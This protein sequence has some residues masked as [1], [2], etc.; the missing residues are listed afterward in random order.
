MLLRR[1]PQRFD[2]LDRAEEVRTLEEDGGS[3]AV[4]RLGQGGGLGH[5]AL[6][7]DLDHL[8]AVA[9]CVGGER[10]AAVRVDAA[11][12]HELLALGRAHRQVAGGGE[13]G[14]SL[15]ETGAGD[16]QP[17]QLRH[18]RLELEHHLQPTLGD[19]RLVGR[20]RR[21]ELA[22]RG[23][24]VDDRRHVVVVHPRAD[25]ADLLFG[26][27]VAR[28]QR[29]QPLVDLGL[30]QPVRQR[31]RPAQAQGLGDLLEELG[32]GGDADRVEHLPAVIGGRGG[33]AGHLA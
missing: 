10:L 3:L 6:E 12:D 14:R 4:D 33:V 9:D 26:V 31:Q 18:R 30:A 28:R 20:V 1:R 13:R 11:G 27:G 25:E 15:I 16:R 7:T 29:R 8:G 5:A 19:L 17:G 22:A 21:E 24:R 32:R 2:V 23:D